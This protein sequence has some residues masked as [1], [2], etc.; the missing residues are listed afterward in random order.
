MFE[1]YNGK[2]LCGVEKAVV[3]YL[4]GRERERGNTFFVYKLHEKINEDDTRNDQEKKKKR[5]KNKTKK[6][7][8][9]RH[10]QNKTPL[11]L[12]NMDISFCAT[13]FTA[14]RVWVRVRVRVTVP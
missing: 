5:T 7:Q 6:D 11:S 2:R 13:A 9:K 14:R 10:K 4:L 12:P 1:A 3:Y 8:K